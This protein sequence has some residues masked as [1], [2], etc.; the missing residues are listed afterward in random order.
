VRLADAILRQGHLSEQALI[1]VCM[2]GERPAH[3]ERCDICAARAVDLGRWLEEVRITGV[4]DADASFPAERLAAQETQILRRLEQLDR[5]AR[6]LAFPAQ[7]R[8]ER[9][10]LAPQ[11][12]RPAW[13]GVAAAAG[14][15]LGL[16]GG[17][18][19]ARL[20][21]QDV[22]RASE[23]VH[24]VPSTAALTDGGDD[25]APLL[26]LDEVDRTQTAL[27]TFDANTPNIVPASEQ[28]LRTNRQGR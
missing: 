3:L 1:E 4:E 11:G 13:V 28:V 26:A 6:V 18:I 15:V 27:S 24:Q 16:L 22:P 20:S 23:Q 10:D 9:F 8:Y 17:Q 19:S 21:V 2:T 14:L 7:T 25:L 5:P 12:I